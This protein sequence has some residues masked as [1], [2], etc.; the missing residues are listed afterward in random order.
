MAKPV[1]IGM[2]SFEHMHGMKYAQ[3]VT[4][5]PEAELV[6]VWH[7]DAF[8]GTE[9]ATKFQTRYVPDYQAILESDVDGVIICSNNRDHEKYTIAAARAGKHIM[10]EKPFA[11][12]MAGARRMVGA[13]REAGV[14]LATAFPMRHAAPM[15]RLKGL[16]QAGTIGQVLAICGT[17]HGKMPG[18]WFIDPALSG[19]GA[20]I[21][22]TVHVSDLMLWITGA[23]ATEVYAEMDCL[24]HPIGVDDVGMLTVSFDSGAF[25]TIDTSWVHPNETYPIW[26]DVYLQVI[27]TDGVLTAD[28]FGQIFATYNESTRKVTHVHW[29]SDPD[30]WLVHD[31]IGAIGDDR[32]PLAT[33]VDGMRASEIAIAAYASARAGRPVPLPLTD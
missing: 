4:E 7:H 9:M 6:A 29:G 2:I 28:A 1:R 30:F 13:C 8:R 23:N 25:A 26:P 24:L 27:G 10:V 14:K 21:D 3:A 17:N 11:T 18:G 33:G 5:I 16:V 32:E 22:H 12:S 15:K 20:V 31:F 19:G